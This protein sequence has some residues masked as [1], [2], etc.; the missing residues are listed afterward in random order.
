MQQMKYLVVGA[1]LLAM[2]GCSLA[3]V[4]Q[5]PE[6]AVGE[7][8]ADRY[9]QEVPE[10]EAARRES[11]AA[12]TGWQEV[13]TD[14]VLQRLIATAL[15]HNR[16][17]RE[18]ALNVERY[19]AQYRIRR[20]AELPAVSADGYASRQRTLNGT[21]FST[22][23]TYSLQLGVTAYELDF[24]GRIGSL[25]DQ[26]LEQ[27]LA[28][29]ET[30][31]SVTLSL[32][33][34]V[35]R[36][37]LSWLADRELLRISLDTERLE[38]ESYE[39]VRQRMES[40]VASELDLAQARSS[41]EGVRAALAGYR[42]LVAEQYHYL[43]LLTGDSLSETMLPEDGLLSEV[44]PLAVLPPSLSSQV[45]LQRPDIMAAEHELKAA[46]ANIGAARAAFFPTV[47]LTA[48]A[49][50]ISTELSGLFDGGSG[51]WLF[52]PAVSVPIFTAGRLQAEL[53]VAEIEKQRYVVRYEQAIQNGFREVSD[54]L[55]AVATYAEQLQARQGNLEASEQYFRHA[56]N[57][58]QMG[59]DSFLTLLDAQRSLYSSRQAYLDVKLAQ[60]EN[61]I[62]L[63][64]ALGGGW[65]ETSV[66]EEHG[67]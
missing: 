21:G 50:V 34:E 5:R 58:Y 56:R 19:Q 32:V 39:L 22:G 45:L 53:D 2:G 24:F 64:K 11:G 66:K 51:S 29:T 8:F 52:S 14:P 4:Y 9:L 20:S 13:F 3:P 23:E 67:T 25:K 43:Q 1:A 55:V 65:R 46:N 59:V 44:Q 57:R 33:A 60:L 12:E 36:A 61:Q 26:A 62:D 54:G 40:G 37:Y 30:E 15:Q 47:S 42:R 28:M 38:E 31:K 6:M 18:T 48:A 63:Y 16:D 49:G 17:L 7:T 41:L 35:A 10:T 27:Y